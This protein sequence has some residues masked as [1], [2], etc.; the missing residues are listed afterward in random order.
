[1][2][3]MPIFWQR[4]ARSHGRPFPFSFSDTILYPLRTTPFIRD[5]SSGHLVILNLITQIILSFSILHSSA[6]FRNVSSYVVGSMEALLTWTATY[7]YQF[8]VTDTVK[9]QWLK[10]RDAVWQKT[11][12]GVLSHGDGTRKT[13]SHSAMNGTNSDIQTL[14]MTPFQLQISNKTDSFIW[15]AR[16]WRF[17]KWKL[18]GKILYL[19]VFVVVCCCYCYVSSVQYWFLITHIFRT[20][21]R[22][23]YNCISLAI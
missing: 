12:I 23:H 6:V 8:E 15:M 2:G 4:T 3:A 9:L 20:L 7:R 10:S 14:L 21:S 1:M 19:S 5:T 18:F 17:G 22:I 11:S 13:D 16:E